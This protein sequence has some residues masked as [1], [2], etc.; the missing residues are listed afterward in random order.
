LPFD[1]STGRDLSA[2]MFTKTAEIRRRSTNKLR[3]IGQRYDQNIGSQ[4]SR[5]KSG[6]INNNM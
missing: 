5:I 3:K 6:Q 4:T 2:D 1:R